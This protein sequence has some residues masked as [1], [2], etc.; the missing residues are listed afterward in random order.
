M[1]HRL[2][3]CSWPV[4]LEAGLVMEQIAGGPPSFVLF[5]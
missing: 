1:D 4:E 2:R 5:A 3:H